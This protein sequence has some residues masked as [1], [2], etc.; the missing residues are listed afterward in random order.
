MHVAGG[1]EKGVGPAG[2]YSPSE[3]LIPAKPDAPKNAINVASNAV[4]SFTV[5]L[6]SSA[7]C[8]RTGTSNLLKAGGCDAASLQGLFTI[9]SRPKGARDV[10]H[11]APA[12]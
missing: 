1:L 2:D 8:S 7:G 5:E 12:Y 6:S 4:T 9:W 3:G 10:E 11:R